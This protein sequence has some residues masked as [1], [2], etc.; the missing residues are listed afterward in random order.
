MQRRPSGQ[1]EGDRTARE[2]HGALRV[3]WLEQSTERGATLDLIESPAVHRN[4]LLLAMW[5]TAAG[6][7]GSTGRPRGRRECAG[8]GG[9]QKHGDAV[10]SESDKTPKTCP[11]LE[12]ALPLSL[13]LILERWRSRRVINEVEEYNSTAR[14]P[15]MRKDSHGLPCTRRIAAQSQL[16]QTDRRPSSS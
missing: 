8:L 13:Y 12:R 14:H 3:A 1:H 15:R 6:E 5:K 10:F 16:N 9:R 2:G 11:A 7:S 4:P